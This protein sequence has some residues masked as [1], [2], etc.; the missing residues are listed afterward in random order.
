MVCFCESSERDTEQ[1]VWR[2]EGARGDAGQHG[3]VRGRDQRGAG[4][5]HARLGSPPVLLP[6]PN[7]HLIRFPLPALGREQWTGR[8]RRKEGW[9]E[10]APL[11]LRVNCRAGSEGALL[12]LSCFCSRLLALSLAL[13]PTL[14]HPHARS[15]THA[16]CACINA[17][18]CV[19][20]LTCVSVCL[21]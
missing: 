9:P 5:G 15:F 13:S 12:H 18:V 8:E 6:H 20:L 14:A 3:G 10:T 11:I 7:R 19:C 4:Q 16:L 21:V 2:C 17:R 1:V